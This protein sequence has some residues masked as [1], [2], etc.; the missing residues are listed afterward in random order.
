M[1]PD[2]V[3]D[4]VLRQRYRFHPEG[5][6]LRVEIWAE[7]GSFVPDHMHPRSEERWEV[8]EGDVTFTVAGE[9]LHPSPGERLAVAPGIRHAF[10]NTGSTVARIVAEVEP[11]LDLQAFL[12]DAAALGRAGRYTPR[13]LPKGPGALLDAAEFVERYRDT[14]VV[15]F[16][17]PFLQRVVFPPLARLARR[18]RRAR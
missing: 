14:T 15:S 13:G 11:A 8:L 5:D 17:P 1:D 2:L 6:V 3:E 4:P 12:E 10:E 9:R 16:P 18:R 7:P